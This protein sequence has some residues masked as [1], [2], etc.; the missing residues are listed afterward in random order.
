M[1]GQLAIAQHHRCSGTRKGAS[2][3]VWVSRVVRRRPQ[4]SQISPSL[5]CSLLSLH[6]LARPIFFSCTEACLHDGFSDLLDDC[7]VSNYGCYGAIVIVAQ[8]FLVSGLRNPESCSTSS[9]V[10]ATRL[11]TTACEPWRFENPLWHLGLTHWELA[12]PPPYSYAEALALAKESSK[13]QQRPPDTAATAENRLGTRALLAAHHC[14][15]L[16]CCA[17]HA[18]PSAARRASP[19]SAPARAASTRRNTY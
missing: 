16:P 10:Y 9:P 8:R 13:L 12:P 4:R 2:A 14:Q 3:A 11:K 7:L 5:A 19:S 15:P 17:M 6:A 1:P 18:E